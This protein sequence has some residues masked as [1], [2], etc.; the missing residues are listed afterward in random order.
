MSRRNVLLLFD[1]DGTLTEMRKV[2][3]NLIQTSTKDIYELLKRLKEKVYIGTVSGGEI[4]KLRE[5]LGDDGN[6]FIFL[7]HLFFDYCFTENG[8]VAYKNGQ[9]IHSKVNRKE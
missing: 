3:V 8:L 2:I 9:V 1:V 5:Q 7:A 4:N 6:Y